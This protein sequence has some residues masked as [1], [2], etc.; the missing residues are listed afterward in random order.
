M[1]H[2]YCFFMTDVAIQNTGIGS[3]IIE[4][5]FTIRTTIR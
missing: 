1:F 5:F 4:E 3:R 2:Y